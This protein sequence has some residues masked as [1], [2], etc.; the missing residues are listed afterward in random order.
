MHRGK[1]RLRL[2]LAVT[3]FDRTEAGNIP[4]RSFASNSG[5]IAFIQF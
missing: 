1:P 2:L 3:V 4:S 5:L